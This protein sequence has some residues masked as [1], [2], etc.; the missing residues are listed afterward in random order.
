MVTRTA[1]RYGT[2][3]LAAFLH[4]TVQLV[5]VLQR[6]KLYISGRNSKRLRIESM[7]GSIDRL[8]GLF[9]F[10]YSFS[11]FSKF[12]YVRIIFPGRAI[13]EKSESCEWEESR[14]LSEELALGE[15][16]RERE[17]E[18]EI[19]TFGLLDRLSRL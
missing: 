5:A 3:Y 9:T 13:R 10:L 17:R 8:K 7:E 1:I 11:F 2:V 14:W 15:R 16:K 19:G 12:S 4:G 18:K 6:E